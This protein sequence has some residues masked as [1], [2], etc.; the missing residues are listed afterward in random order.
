MKRFLHGREWRNY[1]KTKL[2]Q[3][4]LTYIV[5]IIIYESNEDVLYL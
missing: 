5:G 2:Q 4:C 1:H 3:N